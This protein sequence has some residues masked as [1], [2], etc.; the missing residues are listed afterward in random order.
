MPELSDVLID[1]WNQVPSLRF[2]GRE[3][4]IGSLSGHQEQQKEISTGV[5]C[6]RRNIDYR[7]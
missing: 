5:L 4:R 7:F 6:V 1:V 2:E 3:D